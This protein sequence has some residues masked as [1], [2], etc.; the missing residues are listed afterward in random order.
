VVDVP[1]GVHEYSFKATAQQ[2]VGPAFVLDSLV[3][4]EVPPVPSLTVDFDDVFVPP[5]TTGDWIVTNTREV[6]Q[7]QAAIDHKAM[8][9]GE[10]AVLN[11]DC[12]G[13]EHTQVSFGFNQLEG[14]ATLELLKD[15]KRREIFSGYTTDINASLNW[16]H[17]IVDVEPGAH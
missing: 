2:N 15:G 3:C 14:S 13:Q 1:E 8:V 17:F 7:G 12:G 5:E 6:D 16:G 9:A 11:L 4:R 10:E